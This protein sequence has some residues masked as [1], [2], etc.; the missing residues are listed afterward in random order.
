M[1]RSIRCTRPGRRLGDFVHRMPRPFRRRAKVGRHPIDRPAAGP[2]EVD[3]GGHEARIRAVVDE[4]IGRIDRTERPAAAQFDPHR[5]PV[6]GLGDVHD[7]HIMRHAATTARRARPVRLIDND[8]PGVHH[9]RDDGDMA[10]RHTTVRPEVENT[11][12]LRP[13]ASGVAAFRVV[14]PLPR[15]A[16]EQSIPETSRAYG[17]QEIPW[18]RGREPPAGPVARRE[19]CPTDANVP[20][21]CEWR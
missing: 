6:V 18:D 15:I 21:R 12:S 16:R 19:R 20:V 5:R 4:T 2:G 3:A 14:P 10:Q 17:T 1:L 11:P 9:A 13:V 8:F 7:G